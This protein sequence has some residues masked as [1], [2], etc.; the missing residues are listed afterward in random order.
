MKKI[1]TF[2]LFILVFIGLTGCNNTEVISSS[3]IADELIKLVEEFD[4]PS[5]V[6][7]DFTLTIS[8]TYETYTVDVTWESDNSAIVISGSTAKVTQTESAVSVSLE[9]SITYNNNNRYTDFDVVVLALSSSSS[10]NEG[11]TTTSGDTTIPSEVTYTGYYSDL[12][13]NFDNFFEVLNEII[14]STHT[15]ELSYSEVWTVLQESD[16]YD[17]DHI[18]CL[19]TGIAIDKDARDGSSSSSVVWNREHVWAKSYGFDSESY[20]AYS[21]A[22]HLRASEKNINSSRSNSYFDEIDN[23]TNTD[24]YGNSW[25]SIV[26]EPRDEVKGDVA[27]MLFYMVTRYSDS[28]LTLTLDNSGNYSSGSPVLGMLD[29]LVKWHYEDPVSEEEIYRNEVVYSY[30]GNRN[31]YIDHPEFVYYLYT[32]ES[33]ELGVTEENVLS[34]V[35]SVDTEVDTT[36][37]D[38]ITD[39]ET[40]RDKT[41]TLDD[42]DLLDELSARYEALSA[43]DKTKITNY[44]LL[45]SKIA[46]YNKLLGYESVTYDLYSNFPSTGTSYS[47][48]GATVTI[49]GVEFYASN[50]STMSGFIIGANN[51]NYNADVDIKYNVDSW[52]KYSVLVFKVEDLYSIELDIGRVYANISGAAILYS[53]DDIT[54][55]K[56]TELGIDSTV[57]TYGTIS[58]TF[59]ETKT[60]YVAI[61][62]YGTQPRVTINTFT[63]IYKYDN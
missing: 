58:Y 46:E 38:L 49:D 44:D 21:D 56:V 47:S 8:V 54:Y 28:E 31:P 2:I 57:D 9:A 36:V 17:E 20:T 50:Y 63:L 61:V 26:F 24:S 35:E 62:V 37:S 41:I 43:A 13:G 60:G 52:T 40:L 29:T 6:S 23:P 45:T 5:E 27:R 12:T 32:E 3:E 15:Y 16:A 30:Q 42:K 48:T 10:G 34:I 4:I 33:E 25:T 22:H 19:Y 53:S 18:T 59:D 7:E 1:Y 14:V 39:I 51:N 55:E 11:G